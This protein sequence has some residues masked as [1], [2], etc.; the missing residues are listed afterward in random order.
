MEGGCPESAEVIGRIC[1]ICQVEYNE[2]VCPTCTHVL[3]SLDSKQQHSDYGESLFPVIC[4]LQTWSQ[5]IPAWKIIDGLLNLKPS[6]RRCTRSQNPQKGP[7]NVFEGVDGA[8]KTFHM[9]VDVIQELLVTIQYPVHKGVF[10][11]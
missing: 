2:R 9:V 7:F 10:P 6:V 1:D 3:D 8:G 5:E 4:S 11:N